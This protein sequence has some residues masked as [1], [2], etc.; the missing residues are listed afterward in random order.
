MA[1][2][3]SEGLTRFTPKNSEKST[4]GKVP[5]F[6]CDLSAVTCHLL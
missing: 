6:G 2:D 5:G 3:V 1:R 4:R